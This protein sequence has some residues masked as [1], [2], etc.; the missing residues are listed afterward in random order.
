MYIHAVILCGY[1]LVN[2]VCA[3]VNTFRYVIILL[4]INLITGDTWLHP[5]DVI[6]EEYE[7][8]YFQC[9]YQMYRVYWYINGSLRSISNLP[10]NHHIRREDN[11]YIMSVVNVTLSQNGTTYQCVA[12]TTQVIYISQVAVLYVGKIIVNYLIHKARCSVVLT[13]LKLKLI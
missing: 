6:I 1:I 7:T 3:Y 4:F 10:H 8:A 13:K 5:T 9:Q 2:D 11:T 12:A